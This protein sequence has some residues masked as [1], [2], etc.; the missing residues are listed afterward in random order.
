MVRAGGLLLDREHALV[1]RL[2]R[3]VLPS[4]HVNRRDALQRECGQL[5]VRA[6]G[7]LAD[8]ERAPVE[9]LGPREVSLDLIEEP[10]LVDDV[11]RLGVIWAERL[12]ADGERAPVEL[13]GLRE[14]AF[15]QVERGEAVERLGRVEV[16]GAERLLADRERAQV[17]WFR[18]R[19]VRQPEIDEA[20]LVDRVRD[21]RG[22]GAERL[23]ADRDGPLGRGDRLLVAPLIHRHDGLV[24]ERGRLDQRGVVRRRRAQLD[25]PNLVA[26]GRRRLVGRPHDDPVGAGLVRDQQRALR[27][28]CPVRAVDLHDLLSARRDHG[29]HDVDPALVDDEAQVL[30]RGQVERV[31]VRPAP[32]QLPLD[33]CGG[34]E[35]TGLSRGRG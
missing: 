13:L 9:R 28:L 35:P 33:G 24:V 7:L 22:V 3:R 20:E 18:R 6:L 17:E 14:L 30:A 4:Q 2:G 16:L 5:T 1:E 26:P 25:D 23:L 10:E 31:R 12:L 34:R 8:R 11:R 27:A 15:V 32:G 29:E 21:E 19:H